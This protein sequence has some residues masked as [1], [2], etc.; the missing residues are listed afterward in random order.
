MFY[1]DDSF[2][3]AFGVERCGQWEIEEIS[4]VEPDCD[5]RER[6]V[7]AFHARGIIHQ[8]HRFKKRVKYLIR[9]ILRELE[10]TAPEQLFTESEKEAATDRDSCEPEPDY[11]EAA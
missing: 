4:G 3:H 1:A 8:N 6:V 2:S 7:E 10:R 11:E 9:Q 5:L